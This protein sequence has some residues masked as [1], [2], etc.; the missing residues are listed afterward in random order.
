MPLA[1]GRRGGRD[2]WSAVRAG[3]VRRVGPGARRPPSDRNARTAL[4]EKGLALMRL[5][6][7][8]ALAGTLLALLPATAFAGPTVK[9]RVEGATGTLLERTTVTLPDTPP[10]VAGGCPRYTAAAALDEGTHGNWDRNAFTQ[11]ILG[12]SH[13]FTDSDYWAEWIDR[14]TGYRFGGGI[15]TDVLNDGDELVMLVDRSPA[16]ASVPTVFPLDLDGVPSSVQAGTPF[17]VTVVAYHTDGTPGTGQPQAVEGATVSGGH[18]SA[19]T[20]RDGKAS[21]RIADTGTVTLKATKPGLATW[22][23]EVVNVTAAPAAPAPQ[24][25]AA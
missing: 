21:L 20:D 19:T 13:T 17:T 2:H 24:R 1:G 16:P 14:G 6:S 25:P 8:G 4:G 15:C 7:S 10:P 3:K 23:G 18:A 22:G 12:E 9:V 11:T 5:T